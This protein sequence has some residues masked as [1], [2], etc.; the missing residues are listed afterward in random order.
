V[1]CPLSPLTIW[2]R[3][4][5]AVSGG[6]LTLTSLTIWL[7]WE[8]AVGGGSGIAGSSGSGFAGSQLVAVEF[9]LSALTIWLRWEQAVNSG[10]ITLT[11]LTIRLRWEQAG[12]GGS[13]FAGRGESCV[14]GSSGSGVA[15]SKLVAVDRASQ[16]RVKVASLGA[17]W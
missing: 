15:A 13:G 5:E 6:M 12:S 8:Q 3:W 10:M 9:L 16:V 4:E 11:S 1:E 7:C 17:S 14:T 2:L